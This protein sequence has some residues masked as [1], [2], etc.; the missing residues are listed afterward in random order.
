MTRSGLQEAAPGLMRRLDT[1][2]DG[3][4]LAEAAARLRVHGANEMSSVHL[5]R[6]ALDLLRSI[7]NPLVV[8]LL[9]A[10]IASAFLGEPVQ[11]GLIA[12]MVVL[13]AGL[14]LWQT[15]RSGRAV[16][17][18]QQQITPTA[19]VRRDGAWA[20][21]A[22]RDIAVGDVIRLSAGDLVPADARLLTAS[23]L[24]AHQAALTGEPMPAEKLA[25]PGA[26][27]ALGPDVAGLVYL[28][29]SIVSGTATAVVFATGKDTAFGD[30]VQRLAERPDETE[31]ERGTRKFG[32]LIMQS[33]MFL[34]LFVLVI[35][36]VLGRD[37]LQ[38]VLFSVALAVGLTP[39]FLPMITSVTLA[40]GAIQMA[41]DKVI[42][43]HLSA[44]QNLGA[45]DVL[46]SDKTG[47]LTAGT[48]AFDS[49]LDPHGEPSER[50]LALAYLNSS[51]ETGIASPLDRAILA[52]HVAGSVDYRK[53]DEIPFDFERRRLSIV[54]ECGGERLLVTKGAPES[55]IAACR[56]YEV[57]GAV[58]DL[59]PVELARC[60]QCYKDASARGLRVLAVAYRAVPEC[61]T[62]TVG[63]ERDLTLAGFVTFADHIVEGI[64]N[65]IARLQTDGVQIKILTGDN[66]LVS[67]AVC[68]QV[69]LDA[70][71]IV[72]GSEI[73][74]L[75]DAALARVAEETTVFAR[76]SPAQKHRIVRALKI[77]GHVVGFLGDG[78]NDAPS[79][80]GADVGI[81]VANAVDVAREASDIILLERHLDVL[82][83]GILAGR[84]SFGNVL[85]YLL[86]GTSS[87][88]GNMFSMA[89]AALFL[90]F[91]PMLPMQILLNNF[92][93][94]LAQVTIPTDRVDE[95]FLRR[96]QRWNIG[97]I[98]KFMWIIGPISSLYDFLT[99]FTLIAVFHFGATQFQ[100][101][102]FVES[103]A[104]QTLVLFVIRTVKRPW[105]DRP[106]TPLVATTI[107]V[108]A[109][110]TVLP[111]TPLASLLGF[112]LL[113]ATFLLLLVAVAGSYL[114]VVELVKGRVMRSLSSSGAPGASP[115]AAD[116]GVH[117]LA[118]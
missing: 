71:R 70:T 11:A 15:F 38:S 107:G 64:A 112:A 22:R 89:G 75:H 78:I 4:S 93:Y 116:P 48:M 29:T 35:N 34:V 66:E 41:R 45:V 54:A 21:V 114:V 80:H 95:A 3:L 76:V 104:T 57:H 60:E 118:A 109:L 9:I 51:F 50:A 25:M 117:R 86:M 2:A 79:L 1:S 53:L 52:C 108:V 43:K 113:P 32:M 92:L 58:R 20:E 115:L 65:S 61:A 16:K 56:T 47:T 10:G 87:N 67:R 14:N 19:T 102:W 91:L 5:A 68:E 97:L 98:R 27:D 42:V 94:D 28:G 59:D 62:Y 13:S 72:L 55:V 7:L 8:I 6:K 36:V 105:R 77:G 44:I 69:G 31:L 39:E 83:A 33:V 12:A 23:D 88:F 49:S 99:F 90:P 46:C 24:H 111:F 37:A 30:V 84:R 74:N 40:Q 81:S 101:G 18:L 96:P 103:L 110:G 85:K 73:E 82:H 100:T 63:D 26:L 17:R 106:S